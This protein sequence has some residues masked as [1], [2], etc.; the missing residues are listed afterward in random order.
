MSHAD[1]DTLGALGENLAL[2]RILPLLPQADSL[3]IGPG[4]DSAVIR[5]G[6][7][8]VVIS[9]DMMIEGPDFQWSWS[10]P[11]QVGYKAIASNAADI[12]A[13][14]ALVVAYEIAVAA[15]A[16]TPV[17]TLER[18]AQ[19]FAQGIAELT[20][21]AG[22]SGGDLSRS[23]VLTI[24]VT[25]IGDL[26]GHPPVTRSGARP[27]HVVA[28]AGELG[29]SRKGYRELVAAG[30]NHEEI[31]ALKTSSKAVVH[32]LQPTPPI[33]LGVVARDAGAT[34]MMDI[35]DG[36]ILD[37]TRMARASGVT[38][39]L[40]GPGVEPL[41]EDALVGGEDHGLLA[42]FP[43]QKSLPEGFRVIGRV[44]ARG[45]LPV[46]GQGFQLPDVRG[47]WDPF[48]DFSAP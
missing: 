20:P 30:A 38:I 31:S 25:V 41:D 36:L 17:A 15:P 48:Q 45:D 18:L 12:A 1:D 43:E 13:M 10:D 46:V 16:H 3:E 47:G 4:D 28:V 32:H 35:S 2:A 29:L 33:G 40:G 7:S 34:A 24:V 6:D 42:C 44:L 23:P 14:G 21:G 39:E 5:F 19:G 11:E 9:C 22:V 26:Q 37:A 8:R 27:G